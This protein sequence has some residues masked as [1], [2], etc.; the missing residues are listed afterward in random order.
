MA[1][2]GQRYRSLCID[3]QSIRPTPAPAPLHPWEWPSQPWSRIHVDYVGPYQ[4]RMLLV[5][6]DAHSKWMEVHALTSA[7]SSATIQSLRST[8]AQLGLPRTV[9]TDNSPCFVSAEFKEFMQKNGIRHITSSPGLCRESS[10]DTQT[11]T[12]EDEGRYTN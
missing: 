6:S 12:E 1:R 3:C 5:L 7:T 11:G 9:V 8:F 2:H 4:G 10:S